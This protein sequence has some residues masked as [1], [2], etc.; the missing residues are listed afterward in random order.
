MALGSAL[1]LTPDLEARTQAGSE[2]AGLV[3]D[4]HCHAGK[5]EALT[6]PW[7]TYNDPEVIL[8]HAEEAGIDRSIIFPVPRA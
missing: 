8:R 5:G 6:A 3:I 2:K 4:A 7:N 1:A